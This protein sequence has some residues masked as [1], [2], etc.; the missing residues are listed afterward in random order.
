MRVL[1]LGATGLVGSRVLDLMLQDSA[2]E[3]VYLVSRRSCGVEHQKIVECIAP[4]EK[5]AKFES[6]FD[7]DICFC[8]LGTTIKKAGSK[9]AFRKIDYQLPL[10]AA[11]LCKSN[12]VKKFLL[13]SAL[14]ADSESFIFY[15]R[16]KGEI[17]ESIS[18]LG[19]ETFYVVR[20][21]LIVGKREESRPGEA[22]AMIGFKL[23]NP[24][25][26]GPI[27]KYRGSTVEDIAKLMVSLAKDEVSQSAIEFKK[28]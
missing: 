15:N 6:A 13:V 17:E 1:I 20:P 14:G 22:L 26:L 10:E 8:C 24:L 11:K 28:L 16:V 18:N 7:V 25:F 2:V 19:I 3:T 4:L 5:M 23:L 27:K 9:E 12:R 21:S